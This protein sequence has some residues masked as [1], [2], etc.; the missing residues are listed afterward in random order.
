VEKVGGYRLVRK[1]GEGER[2]EVWLGHAGRDADGIAAV[3]VYRPGADDIELELE[4]LARASDPHLLGLLDIGT[5]ADGRPCLVLRRLAGPSLAQLLAARESFSAGELV[6]ALA[7]LAAAVDELHRVGVA[8]GGIDPASVLLDANGAPVLARFGRARLVGPFP[9]DGRGASLTAAQRSEQP[10]LVADLVAMKNLVSHLATRVVDPSMTQ[11]IEELLDW[12]GEGLDGGASDDFLVRL[13]D[14]L[15]DLAPAAPLRVEEPSTPEP[16]AL[17]ARPIPITPPARVVERTAA[18]EHRPRVIGLMTEWLDSGQAP[19]AITEIIGRARS[20]A[21]TVRPAVWIAGAVGLVALVVAFAVIPALGSRGS[22]EARGKPIPTT[23]SAAP[24]H[25]PAAAIA[26][27]D[28]VAAARALIAARADCIAQRSVG[29]L[30]EVDQAESA[31]SE[32]DSYFLR[33]QQ[34]GGTVKDR[35]LDAEQATLVQRLGDSAIIGLGAPS[36]S[37]T[38]A[39]SVLVVK[40]DAGWRI[41]DLTTGASP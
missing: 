25:A 17:P 8:H 37:S 12:L 32:A 22:D 31:A 21:G 16:L 30:T 27:D 15:F 34:A 28:P 38:Y 35:A 6:T 26:A 2:A 1:L 20:I 18:E 14:R 10:L 13:S 19:S 29:C 41:R 5:A 7:P 23:H 11:R 40:I 39:E 4:A 9:L 33:E 24:T 3:K 36:A